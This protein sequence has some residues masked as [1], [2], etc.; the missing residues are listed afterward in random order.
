M[1]G[2]VSVPEFVAGGSEDDSKMIVDTLEDIHDESPERADEIVAKIK[3]LVLD[4]AAAFDEDDGP[5]YAC[6]ALTPGGDKIKLLPFENKRGARRKFKHVK[7]NGHPS[8]MINGGEIYSDKYSYEEGT[9][10][11]RKICFLIG[12]AFGKGW[13]NLGPLNDEGSELCIFEG[14]GDGD[15]GDDADGDDDEDGGDVFTLIWVA[16]SEEG[17]KSKEFDKGKKAKKKFEKKKE[18]G[19]QVLL[20]NKDGEPAEWTEPED[21]EQKKRLC[22]LFGVAYGKGILTSFGPLVEEGGPMEMEELRD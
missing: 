15:E 20:V 2:G 5:D 17:I 7:S 19:L 16:N 8:V 10:G 4:E 12:A 13:C 14:D 9:G 6:L 3:Q 21:G 11:K 1:G 18:K 22:F